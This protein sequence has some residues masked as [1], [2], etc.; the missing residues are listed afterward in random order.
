MKGWLHYSFV[1][2]LRPPALIQSAMVEA[3]STVLKIVSTWKLWSAMSTRG[4]RLRDVLPSGSSII[5]ARDSTIAKAAET[6]RRRPC[7][8]SDRSNPVVHRHSELPT[9]YERGV[10]GINKVVGR[11][12]IVTSSHSL[13]S[14][15]S[16]SS[17]PSS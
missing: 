10:E 5:K 8:L 7:G 11:Y 9:L 17:S 15:S 13:N 6:C 2:G 12:H 16:S 14:S 1:P 3:P 4:I